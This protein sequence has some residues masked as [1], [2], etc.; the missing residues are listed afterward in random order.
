MRTATLHLGISLNAPPGEVFHVL[1]DG[2]EHGR[3]T[4]GKSVLDPVEGGKFSYFDGRVTGV[5]QQ[6]SPPSRIVQRLRVADWPA[7]HFA[8]VELQLEPQAEGR[9]TFVRCREESIPADR[10]DDVLEGWSGY[11]EQL[12]SYLYDRRVDVVRRFVEEYKN[13]QDWDSVDEFVSEN[14][15]V[16]IPLP[17]L[18]E[19]REGMRLNGRLMCSA[20]PDV[21]VEREFFVTEGDIVVERARA[22]ATHEGPLMSLP[23]TGRSVFWTELHAYRVRDDRICEVWSEADFMGVMAQ[24]GAVE[25]PE[26]GAE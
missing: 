9:R 19:G 18:P 7:D 22:E 12:S 4:G 11:W 23:A 20:F 10:L 15:K 21:H 8:T 1:M 5:F 3:F 6:V 14:C 26:G 13:H 16:H 25:F 24:L 2:T 17:G